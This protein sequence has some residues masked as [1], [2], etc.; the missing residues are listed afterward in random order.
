[1]TS[2][3]IRSLLCVLSCATISASLP[4]LASAQQPRTVVLGFSGGASLPTGDFGKQASTGYE[5]GIHLFVAPH[6]LKKN[7]S[8]RGDV[9]Y[10]HWAGKGLAE[11][12][13]FRGVSLMGNGVYTLGNRNMS[14][15]PYILAGGGFQNLQASFATNT[16][17]TGTG[18]TS[19]TNFAAQGGAG[20][21]FYLRGFSTF[22]EA[23]G[24]VRFAEVKAVWIPI[25][26]GF[27]F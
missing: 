21:Q 27:H 16:G 18:E 25:T 8:F 11:Q 10:D 20:I 4:S 22:L 26:F 3:T 14:M 23:R 1:M 13:T 5:F 7:L 15:R 24:V 12:A 6:D 9:S 19:S 17:D 2:G